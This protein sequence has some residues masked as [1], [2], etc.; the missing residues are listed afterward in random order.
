MERL[1]GPEGTLMLTNPTSKIQHPKSAFTLVELLVVITIIGILISLLLPAVQSA[2]EAARRLQCQNNL[3][4]IGLALHNYHSTHQQLPC[5]TVGFSTS[6][7]FSWQPRILSFI[8]GN[9]EFQKLDF[10]KKCYEGDNFQY[11]QA[12]HPGFLCPTDPYREKLLDEEGFYPPTRAL[13]Q[14]DYAG[15]QGDYMNA[16]G[17]GQSPPYGNV[18]L[19]V[20]VRGMLNRYGWGCRFEEVRDG[21]SNTIMIGECVGAFC[22]GQNFAAQSF[23]TTAHPINYMNDSLDLTQPTNTNP[24]W[25]ESIGFRSL[26]PGGANFCMGDGSGHFLNENI[27]GTIYRAMASRAGNEVVQ[28]PQ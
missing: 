26:H 17:V 4:Q 24:R 3:K 15:C 28:M 20:P 21:L 25:D 7:Y 22:I 27:D 5:P 2:R 10:T 11:V 1:S 9:A 18:G 23:A 12:I 19:P 14:S 13:S 6:N 8:E 16:T